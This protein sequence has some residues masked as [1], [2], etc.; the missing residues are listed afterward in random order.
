MKRF[1]IIFLIF[2][3]IVSAMNAVVSE[4]ISS[5]NFRMNTENANDNFIS[6]N[7]ENAGISN[8]YNKMKG[9]FTENRGQVGDGSIRYYI[10]GKGAW[11]LDDGVVFELR[12]TIEVERLESV[13]RESEPSKSAVIKINFEG[14]NAVEP[15]GIGL[16]PHRSNF[17]Y[18]NDSSKWCTEVP[19]YQEI[20]YENIYNEIDLRYYSNDKGLK[21]DFIVHLGGDPN[22]I[23][24]KLTGA[25]EIYV[26]STGNI[27]INTPIGNIIDSNLLIYQNNNEIDGVFKILTPVTYGFELLGKYD[28]TQDLIIDP[29]V[30]STF[31]GGSAIDSGQGIQIDSSGNAFVTG[32][33]A[34]LN[35]PVTIGANDTIHNGNDDVFVLKL[36]STG[37]GL[38]YSTFIGGTGYDKGY[39]IQI[40]SSGNAYVAGNANERQFGGSSNFPT[41]PGA[42]DTTYNDWGDIFVLKLN[43][44][45]SS[46]V[47]STFI[48]GNYCDNSTSIAIDS[49]NNVYVTGETHSTDFPTTLGAYD[50]SYNGGGSDIYVLKLNSAGSSLL[51]STFVGGSGSYTLEWGYEIQIDSNG[52]AYVV[53]RTESSNF[54]TTP[55]AYDTSFNGG[56]ADIFLFSLNSAGSALRYSTYIGGN[57]YEEGYGIQVD[58][59]GCAYITGYTGSFNFP[60]TP[61]AYDTT[62]KSEFVLKLNATGTGLVYSTFI[63]DGYGNEIQID[64]SGNAYVT[65]RTDSSSFPTTPGAYDTT[66][67]NNDDVFVLKLNSTGASLIYSTYIGGSNDE[68]GFGIQID[69]SGDAY[70]TGQTASA[71]FP[72]TNGA[73]DT[74]HNGNYD[75]FILKLNLTANNTS[76]FG[77]DLMISEPNVYRTNTIRLFSN[78][79]DIE[80]SEEDLT[81]HF[82][83][84]G[85]S[86][87]VWKNNYFSNQHYNNSRWEVSFTPPKDAILGQY[88]IRVRYN[89]T[90]QLFSNWMSGSLLVLNNHPITIDIKFSK[91]ASIQDGNVS[92][93]IN[94]SDIEDDERNLTV[95]LFYR[96][97]HDLIWNST[98]LSTPKYI[99]NRWEVNFTAPFGTPF[100]D[101]DF[102]ARFIDMDNGYG[103]WQFVNDSLIIYNLNPIVI[104][105]GL[106]SNPIFRTDSM[107]LVVNGSDYET[108]EH[109]LEFIIQYKHDLSNDWLD[110]N[111]EYSIFNNNWQ[112]EFVTDNDTILGIYDFRVKFEDNESASSGWKYL[113]DTLEVFNNKP[114]VENLDLSKQ[115]VFRTY[116]ILI[117]A[118]G[119]DIENPENQLTCEIQ[120]KSPSGSWIDFL[121]EIFI[122]NHWE[123]EFTPS[124]DAELGFYDL[125]VNFTDQ[126]GGYS[127]WTIVEDAI[128]VKNN[129]P[130]ISEQCDD[131]EVSINPIEVDLTLFESDIE[132]FDEN[133]IWSIDQTSV[134]TSLFS[135]EIIDTLDDIFQ[136]IP[137]ENVS[138]SDDI[139]LIL[140]DKDNG[141][142]TKPNVTIQID[143][144]E[145]THIPKVILL[146]PPDKSIIETVT[147]TLEWKL[148]YSGTDEIT[149]TVYLNEDSN[150]TTEIISGILSTT[151]TLVDEL[152]EGKTYYWKVIPKGGIC[153]SNPF[154]FTI[155]QSFDPIYKVNLTAE[156]NYIKLKQGEAAEINLT[157]KNEGNTIDTYKIEYDS[158]EL[159]SGLSLNKSNIQLLKAAFNKVE[160]GIIIASNM[161]I[162]IY[163]IIVKATSLN[164]EMVTDED[165]INVEVYCEDLLPEV[166]ITVYPKS[167]VI[168]QENSDNV[169]LTIS[170]MGNA[171]EQFSIYYE[172]S[173]FAE[174]EILLSKTSISLGIGEEDYVPITITI[175]EDMEPGEYQ[176]EFFIQSEE[177]LNST[178]LTI[179][180]QEKGDGELPLEDSKL[181]K[182]SLQNFILL[183]LIIVIISIVITSVFIGGTEVG[184]YKFLSLFAIPLFNKLHTDNVL[185]NFIRGQIYGYI[186][187]KPG[188]HYNSIKKV[189]RLNNGTFVH[190]VRIL[191]KEKYVYSKR[192]GFYTRFYPAGTKMP[193]ADE[194]LLNEIQQNIVEKVRV[195]PGITQH[196]VVTLLG[197]SQ[198]VISYNLT[199]LSRDNIL[200]IEQNGREKKYYLN[201]DEATIPQSELH[202]TARPQVS[203]AK[204]P[205]VVASAPHQ[206]PQSPSV[207][208]T[209][210]QKNPTIIPKK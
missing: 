5:N 173:D 127:S 209:T 202:P 205:T 89:D 69:S 170:N 126:D 146:S 159:E 115:V 27:V 54:P 121:D 38:L 176:I 59:V 58:S 147:P 33:T 182:G 15:K 17:F 143:S 92:I 160:L 154:R 31:V 199:S 42:F 65:G 29:L 196:E 26:E 139:T 100:G 191:E 9:H 82:E 13:S 18:G 167:K 23:K 81:P 32:Y 75:V 187:A 101:Y 111:G 162:G 125:K 165:I 96:D 137:V 99:N 189:L 207:S 140:T 158:P 8:N 153:L 22:D 192:D 74:T 86:E 179:T 66:Y 190:H 198:Q 177:A 84:K 151:Y 46:L 145:T 57:S 166:D 36:N 148:N 1:V 48:G 83:Y 95:E 109:M 50:T 168:E 71:N 52:N 120:Y 10:Q 85:A 72:T 2:V 133:L 67:N 6:N 110:L 64:T 119:S 73:Y 124:K 194:P 60:T 134:D 21:Y 116:S 208:T 44:T 184:K 150:P 30:Y 112:T 180:V 28:I 68:I 12:E 136:I 41:T 24:L 185:D 80:D 87:A 130:L 172:S 152:D 123:I 108:P 61:G 102:K 43:S 183:L 47:Y 135:I 128:E 78:A 141:T 206:P 45:G 201:Y 106:S 103:E 4:T 105:I 3:L 20:Y 97:P 186:L 7:I 98:Y 53:G 200:N 142:T 175:P 39:G 155:N 131:F 62:Y 122:L 204:T 157:I 156:K 56:G 195:N 93:W 114:I 70:V 40:D 164:D 181:S 49:S 94:G 129:L 210:S 197:A 117:Y 174:G 34:S 104:D 76:P 169:T 11:F 91:N 63:G 35:F 88:D 193:I 138:G 51:Y 14:S 178:V 118:N 149:Y 19:N 77:M 113:N 90:G 132:D 55:G 144:K 79:T 107:N 188:D 25:Q 171:P 203:V 163:T 37:S 161:E 16:L